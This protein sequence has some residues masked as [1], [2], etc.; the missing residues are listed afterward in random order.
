MG[1]KRLNFRLEQRKERDRVWFIYFYNN[2]IFC[3]SNV[4]KFTKIIYQRN[5]RMR[6]EWPKKKKFFVFR[7]FAWCWF[8]FSAPLSLS[9]FPSFLY[10]LSLFLFLPLFP[11]FVGFSSLS[12]LFIFIFLSSLFSHLNSCTLRSAQISH[13]N[14][15]YFGT[16][17]LLFT[18][19]LSLSPLTLLSS[20]LFC[21]N[22][23]SHS[24]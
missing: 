5:T 13:V 7:F 2:C 9:L 19:L 15:E 24:F 1:D 22:L 18:L 8:I 23:S 21:F 11:F 6:F 20:Y 4:V 12:L 17:Y 14:L 16:L 3:T 10:H